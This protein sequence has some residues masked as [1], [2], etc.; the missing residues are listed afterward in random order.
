MFKK[1]KLKN[2]DF[3]KTDYHISTLQHTYKHIHYGPPSG[4]T[5][6]VQKNDNIFCLKFFFEIMFKK[7]A[8]LQSEAPCRLELTNPPKSCI[9]R[10]NIT[11]NRNEKIP[12]TQ[13]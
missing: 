10:K 1:S 12:K 9:N 6:T 11:N 8:M 13:F 3:D 4:A 7:L 5:S 2:R